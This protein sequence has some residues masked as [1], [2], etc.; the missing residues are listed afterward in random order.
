MS[1]ITKKVP[2]GRILLETKDKSLHATK[3]WRKK[4]VSQE[5]LT[6]GYNKIMEF[7]KK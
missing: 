5:R 7:L 3:G 1:L 4:G 2:Y 6:N